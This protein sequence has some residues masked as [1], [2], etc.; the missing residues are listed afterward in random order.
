MTRRLVNSY[1]LVSLVVLLILEIP[2]AVFYY[3]LER[4]RFIATSERDA[5]IL[6]SLY[7]DALQT[8]A[9]ADPQPAQ[10]YA[11]SRGSQVIVVDSRGT[12][13][14][15]TTQEPGVSYLTRQEVQTALEGLR[16]AAFRDDTSDSEFL[17]VGVPIASGGQVE[18]ALQLAIDAEGVNSRI[19][20][21]WWGLLAI[22]VLILAALA[23]VGL[24]VA[25]SATQPI[26]RLQASAARFGQGDFSQLELPDNEAPG[27]IRQ[28]A[29]SM[30]LMGRQLEQLIQRQRSFVA[31]AS[32]QLR[33]PLTAL[34]LRLEN[35]EAGFT[36]DSA[37]KGEIEAAIDET[38]RLSN[39]VHDLL[40]LAKNDSQ[41]RI[42]PVDLADLAAERVGIWQAMTENQVELL[43]DL[44]PGPTKAFAVEGAV[45][46]V[47]DNLIDNS[48]HA[49]P[50]G[51]RLMVRLEPGQMQHRLM[52]IDEGPGLT[53][54]QKARATER[55]WRADHHRSGS[56]LG[57]AVVANL[58]D[59]SSG[60]LMLEDNPWGPGLQVSTYWPSDN[61]RYEEVRDSTLRLVR[62]SL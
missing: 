28:L 21:F 46:Q 38:V 33:T 22:A 51:S 36:P 19:R 52:V 3:Q 9:V 40:H 53:D 56:G 16:S 37:V 8:P 32:H 17:F 2:L 39:L 48:L 12:S 61:V 11:D 7:L 13:V 55:F 5:V 4:E 29:Q 57:L 47:L 41:P 42:M 49:A 26:K 10:D 6:A 44:A 35:L 45:E 24:T 59:A 23:L 30:N 25:R 31:D 50:E 14:V 18:G 1:L 58:V 43:L 34:R 20:R 62:R 60:Q 54:E 15:D 27:E